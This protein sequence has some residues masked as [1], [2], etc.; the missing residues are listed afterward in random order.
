MSAVTYTPHTHGEQGA[1][2][3]STCC[4][5][6]SCSSLGALFSRIADCTRQDIPGTSKSM[7]VNIRVLGPLPDAM[8]GSGLEGRVAGP[9]LVATRAD[10]ASRLTPRAYLRLARSSLLSYARMSM[11]CVWENT[12]V[13]M[14]V[15][16]R[17][18]TSPFLS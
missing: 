11:S 5:L 16:T 18:R 7:I 1:K 3:S 13:S 12:R 14:L 17:L 8:P 6:L 15:V 4:N 10:C 2:A 9:C